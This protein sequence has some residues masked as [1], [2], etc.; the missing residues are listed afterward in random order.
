MSTAPT[1]VDEWSEGPNLVR[2]GAP[3]EF[4]AT[5]TGWRLQDEWD[6]TERAFDTTWTD[7]AGPGYTD[8]PSTS[9]GCDEQRFLVRWRVL[10]DGATIHALWA[11]AADN[12]HEQVTARTGWFD[13]DGCE[14]PA[15]TLAGSTGG[16][17]LADVAVSV[18]QYWPAV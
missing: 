5:L 6:L 10:D 1:V 2:G 3:P 17:T 16:S 9:N 15:I 8:F 4:P 12:G 18:Q 7:I 13:L 11:D 14:H